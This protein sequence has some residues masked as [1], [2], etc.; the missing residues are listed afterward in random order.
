LTAALSGCANPPAATYD[1]ALLDLDGV[2]YIGAAAA[3]HAVA[4]LDEARRAGMRTAYLTNNASRT[5]ED[6]AAQ[7]ASLEVAATA[8]EIVTSA[9]AA[10]ALLA[11]RLGS[12][13]TVLVAGADALRDAVAAVGL[14]VVTSADD[15]PRAVVLGYDPTLDYSRLAEAALAIRRGAAFVASNLDATLPTPRGLLP[16]MGS[17]AALVST[18]TGQQPEAAGK[19]ARPLFDISVERTAAKRPLV[20]GDRLD[21]DIEG[22]RRAGI[23]SMVV[24]TGVATLLDLA[25]APPERRPDLL[26][27]D[28]RGL[29]R[30]H[31]AARDGHCG[32][33]VAEYDSATKQIVVRQRGNDDL[34]ETLAAIATAAWQALD[35]GCAVVEVDPG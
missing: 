22:A 15:E 28:L 30:P 1:V 5:P 25:T 24:M 29:N 11:E 6:V 31:P 21:T 19:P 27:S 35:D 14:R 18:A 13:D 34:D 3:P 26:A 9:Q 8:D 23:P 2:V 10:A 32:D 17:L 20:V 12:G 4:S 33:A 7:L 16:G